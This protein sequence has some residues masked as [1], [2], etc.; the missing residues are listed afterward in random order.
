MTTEPETNE[1]R[2]FFYLICKNPKVKQ[3]NKV[4][5]AIPRSVHKI[6]RKYKQD[7]GAASWGHSLLMMT[8][9]LEL[10]RQM[11]M[12]M[13]IAISKAIKNNNVNY[14]SESFL[15]EATEQEK[16]YYESIVNGCLKDGV[17]EEN[18]TIL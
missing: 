3:K 18:R 4:P 14:F 11:L 8:T 16:L 5:I 15:K 7:S 13:N 17:T 9:E 1:N 12:K 10:N 6:L 2:S